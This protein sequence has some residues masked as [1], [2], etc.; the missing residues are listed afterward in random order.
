MKCVA[1]VDSEKWKK[2][3]HWG[4]ETCY[5]I[6]DKDHIEMGTILCLSLLFDSLFWHEINGPLWNKRQRLKHNNI[7]LANGMFEN[8]TSSLSHIEE[9]MSSIFA[10]N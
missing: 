2:A 4:V 6:R 10:R 1:E 8:I 9:Y 7:S 5:S 3:A